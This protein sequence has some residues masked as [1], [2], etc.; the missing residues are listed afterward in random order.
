MMTGLRFGKAFD[1]ILYLYLYLYL[2]FTV[3]PI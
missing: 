1:L 3:L 2:P